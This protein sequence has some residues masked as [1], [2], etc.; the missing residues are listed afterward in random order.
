MKSQTSKARRGRPSN[1][2]Q[3]PHDFRVRLRPETRAKWEAICRTQRWTSTEA[4]DALAD[5]YMYEHG[6]QVPE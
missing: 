1:A 2:S 6:I 3:K 4:A 5:F